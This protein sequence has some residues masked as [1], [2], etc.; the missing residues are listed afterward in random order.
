M[1]SLA[2]VLR[3]LHSIERVVLKRVGHERML[4]AGSIGVNNQESRS[5][6]R[7]L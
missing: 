6:R 7:E 4:V 3:T 2:G 5:K 1:K